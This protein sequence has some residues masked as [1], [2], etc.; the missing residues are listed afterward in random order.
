MRPSHFKASAAAVAVCLVPACSDA[1]TYEVHRAVS[2]TVEHFAPGLSLST[3]VRQNAARMGSTRWV[4]HVG[5]IGDAPRGLFVQARLYPDPEAR[6]KPQLQGDAP[7]R[8]IEL[9]ADNSSNEISVMS[10]LAIAFRGIPKEGCVRLRNGDVEHLRQVRYW[11]APGSAGGVA[12]LSDFNKSPV[13]MSLLAWSG[14]F[15]GTETLMAPFEAR[16]C[17]GGNEPIAMPN[18]ARSVDA[19]SALQIAFSDS[20][21]GVISGIETTRQREL[22]NADAPDACVPP[23]Q[24]VQT[25]RY[26]LAGFSIEVPSDFVLVRGTSPHEWRAPD[27]SMIAVGI[28]KRSHSTAVGGNYKSSCDTTT[29]GRR[30]IV[31]VVNLG[32]NI[33]ELGVTTAFPMF[34]EDFVFDAVGPSQERQRQLL[35]AAYSI[36]IDPDFRLRITPDYR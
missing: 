24:T 14:A 33:P 21:R 36:Q 35:R 31:G 26:R 13:T 19:V 7:V 17:D 16:Q 32:S 8:A 12:V 2:A 22:T 18:I 11:A 9:L 1:P 34:P 28:A 30:A 3:P 20:V 23:E 25:K 27:N 4:Q 15:N 10:D 29:G 5:L 6:Q